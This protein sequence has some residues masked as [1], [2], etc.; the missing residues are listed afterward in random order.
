MTKFFSSLKDLIKKHT[1]EFK[2]LCINGMLEF[3]WNEWL[4]NKKMVSN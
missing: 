4:A 3:E 1:N 2:P